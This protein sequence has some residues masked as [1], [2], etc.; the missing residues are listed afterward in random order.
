LSE[1]TN[2]ILELTEKLFSANETIQILEE[3]I[4]HLQIP[5]DPSPILNK[6]ISEI[7][8]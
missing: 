4:T 8:A 5:L 1:K 3:R 6:H 7:R 2:K